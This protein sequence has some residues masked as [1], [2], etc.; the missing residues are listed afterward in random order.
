MS[1]LRYLAGIIPYTFGLVSIV[2]IIVLCIFWWKMKHDLN[3]T[4]ELPFS[5]SRLLTRYWEGKSYETVYRGSLQ[6]SIGPYWSMYWLLFWRLASFVFFFG[7]TFLWNFVKENGDNAHFFTY[8]NI[9]LITAYYFLVL[10]ASFIG[11]IND[12]KFEQHRQQHPSHSDSSET[13][14]S[15][16]S[17][18]VTRFGYTVQILYEITGS[19]AFFITV[20]NF[21]TLNPVFHFWNVNVHFMT[22]MSILVELGLNQMAVRWEHVLFTI[23]WALMYLIFIWPLVAMEDIHDWPYFFLNAETAA[24][25]PW[26]AGLIVALILFYYVFWGISYL[27]ERIIDSCEGRVSAAEI[28]SSHQLPVSLVVHPEVNQTTNAPEEQV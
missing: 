2:T 27:K 6:H 23:Y 3:A 26:Y 24:V 20:V 28:V 11:I 13:Q 18:S 8:W 5:L 16:W 1:K 7:I 9:D 19:T 22:S 10:I 25:F 17:D 21:I 14:S 15:F 12:S 4:K